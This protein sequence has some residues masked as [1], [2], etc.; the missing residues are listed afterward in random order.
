MTFQDSG[1]SSALELG[2][3][4]PQPGTYFY[5]KSHLLF[6]PLCHHVLLSCIF[7]LDYVSTR[8]LIIPTS[9]LL[10]FCFPQLCLTTGSYIRLLFLYDILM[11]EYQTLILCH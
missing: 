9:Y 10:H 3:Y 6:T 4:Q 8:I 5:S 11:F 2:I 1:T 7:H